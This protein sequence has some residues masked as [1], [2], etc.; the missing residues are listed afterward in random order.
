MLT[1]QEG[2][3]TANLG[4]REFNSTYLIHFLDQVTA[5]QFVT[6][7]KMTVKDAKKMAFEIHHRFYS[8]LR[9]EVMLI[10]RPHTLSPS[11]SSFL[12]RIQ[13]GVNSLL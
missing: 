8:R 6:K 1:L 11:L 13:T 12:N 2:S 4:I 3:N 5:L 7:N 10:H 9:I